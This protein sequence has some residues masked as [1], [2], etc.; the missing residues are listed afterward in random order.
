MSSIS[1]VGSSYY[2]SYSSYVDTSG[3]AIE[4]SAI[5]QVNGL[6]T[7]SENISSAQSLLNISDDAL[8]QITEYLQSIYE[9]SVQASN[10]AV[11]SSEDLDAIQSQIDQYLQGIEDIASNTTYNEQ[12]LLD[13]STTDFSITTDSNGSSTTVSTTNSTLSALGIDG[14]DIT[15]GEWDISAIEDA[16]KTVTSSRSSIGAQSNTLSYRDAYNQLTSQNTLYSSSVDSQLEEMI[17]K[18]QENKKQ[19]LLED[20]RMIMQKKDEE[21]MKNST[22][23]LFV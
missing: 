21:N 12:N 17:E 10:T 8:G 14:Y 15:S 7:G 5:T 23:N 6:D 18:Y 20:V 22:M 2:S 19:Q 16:L 13:G 1:A 11:Y 4:Q 9:L 3:T